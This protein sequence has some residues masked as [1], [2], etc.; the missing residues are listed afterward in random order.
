ME[1][2]GIFHHNSDMTIN[3]IENFIN[4]IK[5]RSVDEIHIMGGEPT[6][7]P[8]FY[9]ICQIFKNFKDKLDKD[10]KII[11]VSE[12]IDTP[13]PIPIVNFKPNIKQNN[14]HRCSLV[15]PIDIG[16][17]RVGCIIPTMC[18]ISYNKYGCFP[19]G[20]GGSIIRLF[21]MNEFIKKEI[22]Q[23]V[24]DWGNLNKVCSLCQISARQQMLEKDFGR[25]ISKSFA[26]AL[27]KNGA[28]NLSV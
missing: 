7:H 6:Q 2:L 21:G 24:N 27:I 28:K 22:P 3:E 16:Q 12:H 8:Q 4:Q 15:A 9:E 18:G 25:P 1:D 23:S 17:E 11:V 14:H 10:I 20:A 13:S 26:D 19:C 5:Y